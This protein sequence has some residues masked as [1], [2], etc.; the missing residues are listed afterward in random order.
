[1]GALHFC[2][3][4]IGSTPPSEHSSTLRRALLWAVSTN[5]WKAASTEVRSGRSE[6]CPFSARGAVGCN[7]RVDVARARP[8]FGSGEL[9][10]SHNHAIRIPDRGVG[11]LWPTAANTAQEVSSAFMPTHATCVHRRPG[12]R[13]TLGVL[14]LVGIVPIAGC[15]PTAAATT[16]PATGLPTPVPS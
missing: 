12:W 5:A 14:L 10:W 3:I 16:S 11:E 8:P 15:A 4:V 13:T 6:A 9:G 2:Q 1:M 7:P